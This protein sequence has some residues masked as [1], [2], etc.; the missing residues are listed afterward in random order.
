[1]TVRQILRGPLLQT[2]P[3]IGAPDDVYEQEAN[4][5]ADEIM[6]MPE[7]RLRT[8]PTCNT[9]VCPQVEEGSIQPKLLSD[10][11][12]PLIQRQTDE[13]EEEELI[14]TK[15]LDATTD[16][17]LQ[18]QT[19]EEEDELL[20]TTTAADHTPEVTPKVASTIASMRGGG[21]PLP[22]LEQTFFEPRFGNDFSQVRIHTDNQ[23]AEVARSVNARAFTAGRDV[24]FGAGEYAPGAASGRR[25]MAHELTHVIQQTGAL[26]PSIA[27]LKHRSLQRSEAPEPLAEANDTAIAVDKIDIIDSS[28]GAVGGFKGIRGKANLNKPGPFENRREIKNVHQVKFYLDKGAA[29]LLDPYRCYMKREVTQAGTE[30]ELPKKRPYGKNVAPC[31]GATPDGPGEHEIKSDSANTLFVADAPGFRDGY[32][33]PANF[34]VDFTVGLD[35][36]PAKSGYCPSEGESLD[37]TIAYIKYRVEIR[38]ESLNAKA[39]NHVEKLEAKDLVRNRSL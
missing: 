25:L 31:E 6:R 20:Q 35:S 24:V 7:P 5:V 12:L 17:A 4:R 3:N 22:A 14:Q 32:D 29:N 26:L 10:Q 33:F 21:Q 19:E 1:M 28:S 11:I 39:I 18:R 23:A 38:K 9:A 27:P 13:E 8:S 36:D 37:C 30:V 34:D 15:A 16:L 2:K